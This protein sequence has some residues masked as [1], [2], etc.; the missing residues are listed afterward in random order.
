M[1]PQIKLINNFLL[2]LIIFRSME[3]STCTELTYKFRSSS[4]CLGLRT[5]IYLEFL[6]KENH[7]SNHP[8]LKV[9]IIIRTAKISF[10]L[11]NC[12]FSAVPDLLCKNHPIVL[13]RFRKIALHCI[14]K[15]FQNLISNHA[16]NFNDV[17]IF[18]NVLVHPSSILVDVV[19]FHPGSFTSV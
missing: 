11:L 9:K 16:M 17:V 4:Q 14:T 10:A 1:H 13:T 2:K 19:N 6:T 7:P 8:K 15:V 3:K 12:Y 5:M 18:T